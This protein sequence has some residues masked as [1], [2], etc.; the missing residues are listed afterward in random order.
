MHRRDN[1]NTICQK[2]SKHLPLQWSNRIDTTTGGDIGITVQWLVCMKYVPL[3]LPVSNES[4]PYTPYYSPR[5]SR[6]LGWNEHDSIAFCCHEW[7]RWS[8]LCYL[9]CMWSCVDQHDVMDT[10]VFIRVVSFGWGCWQGILCTS[11][12]PCS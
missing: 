12:F 10:E 7:I 6:T 8:K 1:N 11:L 2:E 4:Y 3:I 9:L 5:S